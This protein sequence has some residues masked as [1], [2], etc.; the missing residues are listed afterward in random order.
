MMFWEGHKALTHSCQVL[1]EKG[2]KAK[3]MSGEPSVANA[4]AEHMKRIVLVISVAIQN[5]LNM[6]RNPMGLTIISFDLLKID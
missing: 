6:K 4:K 1:A 3:A 5:V 2:D